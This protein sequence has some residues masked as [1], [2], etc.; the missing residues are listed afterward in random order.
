MKQSFLVSLLMMF[1][2][3][4]NAQNQTRINAYVLEN[5]KYSKEKDDAYL[6]FNSFFFPASRGAYNNLFLVEE[7]MDV[8]DEVYNTWRENILCAKINYNGY[9][10]FNYLGSG[11]S[12]ICFT[13]EK[14]NIVD[15]KYLR[16]KLLG[17]KY[18]AQLMF[19]DQ[20]FERMLYNLSL[21]KEPDISKSLIQPTLFIE[22]ADGSEILEK[23]RAYNKK[24]KV[25][26]TKA[27]KNLEQY[28]LDKKLNQSL[29]TEVLASYDVGD[30]YHL[31]RIISASDSKLNAEQ[32]LN[33]L[34]I[35]MGYDIT[36][37]LK[38]E[39]ITNEK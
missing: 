35:K 9:F 34:N 5:L 38:P 18:F 29:L 2:N 20:K 30:I 22:I 25:N 10:N 11:Y 32:I 8:S 17:N 33:E 39:N 23:P 27:R 16:A 31:L 37:S 21:I 1:F 15:R 7:K 24:F 36:I 6:F 14:D 13:Y 28:V 26:V 4:I 3:F 12:I 19:K